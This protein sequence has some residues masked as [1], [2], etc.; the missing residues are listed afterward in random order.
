M[1]LHLVDE[2]FDKFLDRSKKTFCIHC[3]IDCTIGEWQTD[4]KEDWE[5]ADGTKLE[6]EGDESVGL[7]PVAFI[8]CKL[9]K[10]IECK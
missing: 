3:G 9:K 2:T 1:T 6:D 10:E 7:E 5:S 8:N 4:D